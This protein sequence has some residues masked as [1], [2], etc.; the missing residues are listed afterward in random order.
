MSSFRL[1]TGGALIDRQQPIH[2]YFDGKRY[3]G[4]AGDTIASALLANGIRIVGRSFKY[5]RPRGFWGAWWEEPNGLFDVRIREGNEER[6]LSNCQGTTTPLQKGMHINSINAFPSAKLDFKGA[7]DKFHAFMPAGFYY[8]TFMAPDWHLFEPGIRKMAGLGKLQTNNLDDYVAEQHHDQCE[9][10]V[11]GAGPA[12]IAAALMA[13]QSGKQV[14]LVDDHPQLGGTYI[15]SQSCI[16]SLPAEQWLQQQIQALDAAGVQI[17]LNTTAFGIYD[18]QLVALAQRHTL[19]E[20]PSLWRMRAQQIVIATGAIDRP[21]MFANNDMPGVMSAAG[22]E[23][24]FNQF[25]VV[26]GTH[27]SSAINH[28]LYD[29]FLQQLDDAGQSVTSINL[30]AGPITATG[31]RCLDGVQQ[32]QRR[33]STDCILSSASLSPTLHLWCQAG[34]ELHWDEEQ[35]CFVPKGTVKNLQVIGAAAGVFNLTEA[36]EQIWQDHAPISKLNLSLNPLPF[37]AEG[38]Q[39]V[40]LQNDVC[41]KDIALA[42]RENYIS[43]EHLKRY[44]TLGMATDQGKTANINALSTMAGLLN[45]TVPEVG[46]TKFRPPF[47]PMPL[48]IYRSHHRNELFHPIKRLTLENAHRAAGAALGEY[49][50]WLRPGWYNSDDPQVAIKRECL[51]ARQHVGILDASPLGKIE[52]MGPDAKAFINF[53]YYNNMA[54]LKDHHIRYG[55]ML[56]EDGIVYDDGVLTK[57]NDNHFL[58]S[59]SSSHADGVENMLEMWRQDGNNP[60]AIYVHDVTQNWNTITVTGPK[61]RELLQQLDLGIDLD[62][63]AFPHMTYREGLFDGQIAKV[64]RVSFT[65]DLS[66]EISVGANQAHHLWTRVSQL[67]ADLDGGPIGIEALSVLRAEKGYIMIGRDTDGNTMPHD[68][69]FGAP[70]NNKQAAYVGD[71]S[72]HSA[73]ANSAQRQQL[74][75]LQ[76][77]GQVPLPTGAHIIS[78]TKQS[79]GFVTSSYYSYSL[80]AP[81]ALAL[82]TA[83]HEMLGQEVKLFHLDDHYTAQIVSPVFYDAEG[84]KLHA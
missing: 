76:V 40:D 29:D 28:C 45:K 83:G 71:R 31:L 34:G 10:L 43:V 81:I 47:V 23:A 68:L 11:V 6:Y 39:W 2:F 27:I 52:V 55:F 48:E 57:L 84:V 21:L 5:H 50:G 46:T 30:G 74:V 56:R 17:M 70:R 15:G 8:K 54:T 82:V 49:G 80:Q 59:C 19:V 72:L 77:D 25:G 35:L 26:T 3:A 73:V 32:A 65:G 75:G 36:L 16:E 38:R 20:A 69:G 33:F 79:L 18:H 14:V 7:L 9:V 24:Y 51:Q 61:A 12:G 13:A 53:M 44:T 62:A 22:A 63:G 1:A 42:Q 58:V 64:A 41:T 78:S 67:A 66:Y 60:D 37:S 4:F